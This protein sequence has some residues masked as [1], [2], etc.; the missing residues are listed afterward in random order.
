MAED[1]KF[2]FENGRFVNRV[3]GEEIPDD[4]PVIIFRAR[5]IHALPVLWHYH[6]CLMT[7]GGDLHHIQAVLDRI[8]EF[9]FFKLQNPSRMK[10]PG[11]T[12]DIVHTSRRELPNE[13]K[14]HHPT[15]DERLT[16]LEKE[17]DKTMADINDLQTALDGIAADAAALG[18]EMKDLEAALQ[19]AQEAAANNQP[20][21]LTQAILTARNAQAALDAIVASAGGSASPAPAPAPT[22][23]GGTDT[24][25]SGADTSGASS[26]DTPGTDTSGADTS[27][28]DTSGA[29]TSGTDTSGADTSGA[30][31][32]GSSDV[33]P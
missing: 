26:T 29:D 12:H 23:A 20:V 32:S 31:G 33:Q 1:R 25:G 5:D 10:D 13:M 4:E 19:A 22:D 15:T 21:D 11:I 27:G 6:G 14:P 17:M 3:S 16:T 18:P 9:K 7:E 8:E 2:K 30:D 24:S 28:T